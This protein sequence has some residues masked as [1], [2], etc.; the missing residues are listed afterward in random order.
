M[1]DRRLAKP[2]TVDAEQIAIDVLGYIVSEPDLMRR[3]L[4]LTG[5][6]AD[7][8][9]QAAE[10]TPPVV[11]QGH[12][13]RHQTTTLHV[14]RREATPPP[15]VLGLVKRIL[16]IGAI[17][18]ELSDAQDFQIERGHE[19]RVFIDFARL[20]N[21]GKGQGELAGDA[22]GMFPHHQRPAQAPP[23]DHHPALNR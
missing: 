11:D 8:I 14:L 2:A 4:D 10:Q 6:E 13:P 7:G 15:L 5:I 3:L 23:Q 20:G 17:P 21:L 18:I 9:R 1:L 19:N 22:F 16:G 12:A